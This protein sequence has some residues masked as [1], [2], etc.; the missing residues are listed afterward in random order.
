MRFYFTLLIALACDI[1]AMAQDSLN[2]R[3]ISQCDT[4]IWADYVALNGDYAVVTSFNRGLHVV[5]ISDPANPFEVSSF[6]SSMQMGDLAISGQ[7]AYVLYPNGGMFKVIDLGNP[8]APIQVGSASWTGN[9]AASPLDIVI[10]DTLAYV[11]DHFF[12]LRVY[13]IS[14]PSSPSLVCSCAVSNGLTGSVA[15]SGDFAFVTMWSEGFAIIN[16]AD[17]Q[18]PLMVGTYPGINNAWGVTVA[19]ERLYVGT[20]TNGLWLFNI[21]NPTTPV[22]IGHFTASGSISNIKQGPSWY[23]SIAGGCGIRIL[24]CSVPDSIREVGHYA[25]G[26]PAGCTSLAVADSYLY[27]ANFTN[28]SIYQYYGPVG[29][30]GTEMAIPAIPGMHVRTFPNPFSRTVSIGFNIGEKSDVSLKVYDAAGRLVRSIYRGW[31]A[32]GCHAVEWQGDD[33]NGRKTSAGVYYVRLK[34]GGDTKT[35]KILRLK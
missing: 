15:L 28:F 1:S 5:N 13:N 29:V 19:G 35:S 24:D 6:D 2:I 27:A 3:M 10:R 30:S 20:D 33:E 16:L 23:T 4:S 7:Y 31:V 14:V 21:S 34:A 17:I 12:G 32:A 9:P 22:P 18:N 26:G 8:A 11:T 25:I